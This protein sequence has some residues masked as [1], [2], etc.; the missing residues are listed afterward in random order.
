MWPSMT[1]KVRLY[2]IKDLGIYTLIYNVSSNITIQ[3]VILCDKEEL[4]SFLT[5]EYV[6]H[7]FNPLN[8][9]GNY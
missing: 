8:S 2:L 7:L 1:F 3:Y 9:T 4:T 6:K 5:N